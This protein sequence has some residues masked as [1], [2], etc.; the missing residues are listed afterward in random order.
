[1]AAFAATTSGEPGPV[2]LTVADSV[3]R[4]ACSDAIGASHVPPA[5]AD[6][7]AVNAAIQCLRNS[8]RIAILAGQGA[9][10]AGALLKQLAELL[11]APVLATRS[12]RGVISEDHPLAL[13]FYGAQA[14]DNANRLMDASDLVLV[15][16]CKL[17]HNG[18]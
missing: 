1:R 6:E 5:Y 3:M 16:G 15:L 2:L 7:A 18:T 9:N 17:T 12:A 10:A 13:T 14:V 11:P 4:E 8:K